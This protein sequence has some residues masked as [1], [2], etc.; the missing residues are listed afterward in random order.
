[1]TKKIK[2]Y[3]DIQSIQAFHEHIV[4]VVKAPAETRLDV[5]APREDSVK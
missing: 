4:I 1:M 5:P 3:L 2:D